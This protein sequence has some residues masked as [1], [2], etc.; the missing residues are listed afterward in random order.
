MLRIFGK[1]R[2][3]PEC[4]C[5][6]PPFNFRNYHTIE[7]GED[8]YAAEVSLETCKAC[9]T[10]WLK[11]LIEESH[12]SYSGRWWRVEVGVES[13]A[14]VSVASARDYIERQGNVFVGGSF[15]N[16]TG[17]RVTGPTHIK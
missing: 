10:V 3:S 4:V 16:S 12:H 11:Y 6:R 14:L 9:N 7:L 1:R 2:Q 5:R 13:K 15:F 17:H 8:K